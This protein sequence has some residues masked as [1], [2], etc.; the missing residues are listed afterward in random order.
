MTPKKQLSTIGVNGLWWGSE[1]HIHHERTRS[2][3]WGMVC[4]CYTTLSLIGLLWL[5]FG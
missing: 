3:G 2:F 5:L 1:S 4:G